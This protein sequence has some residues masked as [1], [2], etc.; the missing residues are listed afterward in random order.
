MSYEIEIENELRNALKNNELY[1]VYQPKYS[2]VTDE[3]VGFEALLRWKNKKLGNVSPDKFIHILENIGKIEEIGFFVLDTAL[4]VL[5][6]MRKCFGKDLH[7]AVNFSP[8]QFA[9]ADL[10][11]II[12]AKLVALGLP[13]NSLEVEVTE[14]LLLKN[15]SG[16]HQILNELCAKNISY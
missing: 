8:L 7:M 12:E 4:T 1:L 6:S 10:S 16:V 5:K 14:G 3:I 11:D 9:Q 13:N 15:S 2:L